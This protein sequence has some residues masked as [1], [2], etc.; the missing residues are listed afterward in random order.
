[1]FDTPDVMRLA[2]DLARYAGTRQSVI[3]RNIAN[4]DTPGF[5][6]RDLEDF[7]EAFTRASRDMMQATTRPGHQTG[8]PFEARWSTVDT[9]GRPSPN[10]NTVSLEEEMVRSTRAQSDHTT[11]LTVYKYSLDIM[12]SAIGRGR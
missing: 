8:A 7:S 2:Q 5:R 6:A 1:M 10:G 9:G 3:A 4:A 12:R 11:A